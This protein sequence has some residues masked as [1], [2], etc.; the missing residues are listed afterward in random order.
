MTNTQHAELM[1]ELRA[2]RAVLERNEV[3]AT[4]AAD[5]ETSQRDFAGSLADAIMSPN[6]PQ[7]SVKSAARARKRGGR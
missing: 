1:R 5:H 3:A 7:V 6:P 2:I 4:D